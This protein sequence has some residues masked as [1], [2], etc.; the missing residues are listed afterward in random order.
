[1]A[2]KKRKHT[3]KPKHEPAEQSKKEQ[4]KPKRSKKRIALIA[5]AIVVGIVVVQNLLFVVGSRNYLKV[6]DLMAI[7]PKATNTTLVSQRS[8]CTSASSL[9][10]KILERRYRTTLT[11]DQLTEAYNISTAQLGWKAGTS[12][13]DNQNPSVKRLSFTRVHKDKAADFDVLIPTKPQ[14]D[15]DGSYVF[16]TSTRSV[17]WVRSCSSGNKPFIEVASAQ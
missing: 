6:P 5:A 2:R 13:T 12:P 15:A 11:P 17:T 4:K 7:E 14:A 16:L 3:H 1:M 8:I 10:K 9:Q